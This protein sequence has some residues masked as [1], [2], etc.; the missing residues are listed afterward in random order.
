MPQVCILKK[1]IEK[2][3]MAKIKINSTNNV[4]RTI[5]ASRYRAFK[6]MYVL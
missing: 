3:E 6:T 1:K 4:A 2:R 5:T